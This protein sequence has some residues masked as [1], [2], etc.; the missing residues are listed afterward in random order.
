MEKGLLIVFEGNDGAGKT[1]AAKKTEAALKEASYDVILTREPG[2]SEKAEAI[3]RILLDPAMKGMDARCEALLYAASRCQHVQDT[4][5]PALSEGKIVLCDRFLGSSL[6]YQGAARDLG[7]EAVEALNDFGLQG[8]RPDLTLFLALDTEK[9][10]ERINA[11][12]NLNRLDQEDDVFH[13]KVRQGFDA[14]IQ[15]NPGKY[16][17]IDASKD[18]DTVAG[19]CLAAITS[20]AQMRRIDPSFQKTDE[21]VSV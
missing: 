18:P 13:E 1:T 3:R 10:R 2:G 7:M 5:L 4:I 9:S 21:P 17:V 12:G 20:F 8:L 6:A 16:A 14:L 11:R 19:Q 15:S